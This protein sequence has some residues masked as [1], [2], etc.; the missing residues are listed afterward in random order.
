MNF[1]SKNKKITAVLVLIVIF[2]FIM[3]QIRKTKPVSTAKVQRSDLVESVYGIGTVTANK[4]FNLK[5]A[6]PANVKEIFVHEGDYVTKGSSLLLLE[7]TPVFKAPFS[8]TVTAVYYKVGEAVTPQSIILTL[9]DMKDR[10]LTI[11][12]EQQGAIRV[13][14]GQHAKL[15]FEGLREQTFDGKVDALFSRDGQ[16]LVRVQ[17]PSLP[18]KILPGMTIDVAIIVKRKPNALVIPLRALSQGQVQRKTKSG[19]ELIPV[20]IGLVDEDKVEVLQS[21]LQEGDEVLL[22]KA[23]L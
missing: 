2:S 20:Q 11:S 17:A 18:E 15:S 9:T 6:I 22:P 1:F 19:S 13:E 12:L 7:D 23:T 4:N 21:P 16:F 5:V 14:P 10:Y 3:L 8:G